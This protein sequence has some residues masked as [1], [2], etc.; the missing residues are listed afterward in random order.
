M[1]RPFSRSAT[2][3]ADQTALM[4]AVEGKTSGGKDISDAAQTQ[5]EILT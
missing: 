1:A 4:F 5:A 3:W 2:R